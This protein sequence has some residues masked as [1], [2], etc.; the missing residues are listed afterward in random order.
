[1]HLLSDKF[2]STF[3]RVRAPAAGE[4]GPRYSIAWFNQPIRGTRIVDKTGKYEE[5]SAEGLV[6]DAMRRNHEAHEQK[7]INTERPI[8]V[9]TGVNRP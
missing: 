4:S 2:K 9:D 6:P 3:H 8:E 5:C 1:M 7:E